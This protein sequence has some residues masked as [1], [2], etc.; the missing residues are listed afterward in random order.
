[1]SHTNLKTQIKAIQK[2]FEEDPIY[3]NS[4]F[5]IDTD[6]NQLELMQFDKQ[7]NH[8]QIGESN[9]HIF[10]RFKYTGSLN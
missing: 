1:M 7:G 10:G 4:M 5:T 9:L 6:F 3:Q 2:E 8:L